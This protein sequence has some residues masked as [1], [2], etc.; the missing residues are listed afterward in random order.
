MK[1][2]LAA[3]GIGALVLALAIP[4]LGHGPKGGW[5]GH[6]GWGGG[7]DYCWGKGGGYSKL[8]DDQRKQLD[9]AGQKFYDGTAQL[10]NDLWAKRGEL[11]ILMNTS[12]P[13]VEKARALQKEIS[14]LAGKMAEARLEF[15]LEAKKIAPEGFYGG[16][17]RKG[18]GGSGR[19]MRGY[20]PGSMGGFVQ[21]PGYG[22]RGGHGPG[23]CRR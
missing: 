13:D 6:M 11:R 3:L 19:D 15:L 21:G 14:D 8:T 17:Y 16:G 20:G 2:L 23:D 1:K 7:Q 22:P 5:R 10:R 9:A 18:R 12:D 4:V